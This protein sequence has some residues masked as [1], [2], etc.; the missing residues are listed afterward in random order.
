MQSALQTILT[1]PWI[2]GVI[3]LFALVVYQFT[4]RADERAACRRSA[5]AQ[6]ESWQSTRAAVQLQL[7]LGECE[8]VQE[9]EAVG[10]VRNGPIYSYTL[11]R[12]L[13]NPNGEYFM[14]K[15][16]PS[17]PY[18]KAVSGEVARAVLKGKFVEPRGA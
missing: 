8:V 2:A 9:S 16:T 7:G 5:V 6:F 18:V 17:G 15:S 12:F 14:F 1:V 13:R 4:S 11:T 10:R 3:G